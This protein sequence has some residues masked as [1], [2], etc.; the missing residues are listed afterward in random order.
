MKWMGLLIGLILMVWGCVG[1]SPPTGD[2]RLHLTLWHGVNPP[3]NRDVFL[4]LVQEFN[5]SQSQVVVEP[6]YVGQPDQQIPKL[7][8]AVVGQATPDLWLYGPSITGRLVELDALRPVED[9]WGAS[10]L[11]QE[12]DPAMLSTMQLGAHLWSVP[13]SV[14]NIGVYYRP[15]LFRQAGIERLPQTWDEFRAVAQKLTRDRN[16]DGTPD[17]YGI[18]LPLGRGEFTVYIWSP[19]LWSAGGELVLEEESRPQLNTPA[20][21]A[22]LTLWQDLV[23]SGA[24]I[25]SAPER[26][27]E[28]DNFIAGRVAMQISGSW[29]LGFMEQQRRQRPSFDYG[30]MPIPIQKSLATAFG[31]DNLFLFRSQPERE[32]AA[33]QF[34]EYVMGQRFQT[35]WARQTGF[36]PVNVRAQRSEEYRQFMAEQPNSSIFLQLMSAGRSRPLVSSYPRISEHLGRAIEATLLQRRSPTA[37]LEEA[38]QSLNLALEGLR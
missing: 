22:A 15:S 29:A 38:Q 17:Q 6:V 10:P 20:A 11:R 27:Y 26:G 30:V 36:L 4:Q 37:A 31:G 35:A 28:E 5:Q 23:R 25:L 9:F 8:A 32:Q 18:Q 19:F 2:G 3:T 24:A 21:A 12:I 1:S 33:W 34:M 7:L 16:G 14:T 13:M